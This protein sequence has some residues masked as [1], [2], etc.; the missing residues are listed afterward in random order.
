MNLSIKM[1]GAFVTSLEP[2][3]LA[4][5]IQNL[6]TQI[7]PQL[8][9]I[10]KLRQHCFTMRIILGANCHISFIE[11]D[12]MKM[13]RLLRLRSSNHRDMGGQGLPLAPRSNQPE[14]FAEVVETCLLSGRALF[15]GNGFAHL[16]QKI[17]ENTRVQR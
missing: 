11:H 5:R 13:A 6:Y 17:A 9:L 14:Q 8:N 10:E 15:V 16:A 7:V 2:F 3:D 4:K 1:E 12:L